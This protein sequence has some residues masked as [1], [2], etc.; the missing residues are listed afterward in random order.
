MTEHT[1]RHQ[2]YNGWTNYETWSVAL[3]INNDQVTQE[4]CHQV[5]RE[6]AGAAFTEWHEDTDGN[7]IPLADFQRYQVAEALKEW[8]ESF[9]PE[10]ESLLEVGARDGLENFAY[11]W[12]QLIGAALSDVDW[13]DL[14]ESFMRAVKESEEYERTR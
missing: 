8:V 6:R 11:L 12:S 14:A 7:V 10:L 3:I 5:V 1:T 13:Y 4:T 9:Q 2:E